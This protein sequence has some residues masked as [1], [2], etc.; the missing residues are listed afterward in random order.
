MK[1]ENMK[2]IKHLGRGKSGDSYLVEYNNKLYTLKKMHNEKVFYYNF[3]DTKINHEIKSYEILKRAGIEIPEL[4]FYS[5]SED[6]L[7]KEF[8]DGSLASEIIAA[9]GIE[10]HHIS[11][12]FSIEEKARREGI[13]P[14]YFP[15]NFIIR[16]N[17]VIYIDYE[18]G[19]YSDE[20]NFRNWG[21]YYWLNFEG[22][23]D[24]LLTRNPDYINI[25]GTGKPL[26]TSEVKERLE[27]FIIK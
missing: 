9:E 16:D 2:I 14:D 21:I 23:R 7:I 6:Y 26:I 25:Q 12:L 8:I 19:E 1:L 20:W 24:F 4:L 22:F 13:N 27:K 11:K 10:E 15:S 17:R 5:L 18:A 3:T